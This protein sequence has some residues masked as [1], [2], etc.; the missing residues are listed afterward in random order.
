MRSLLEQ[1]VQLQPQRADAWLLLASELSAAGSCA[2]ALHAYER[3]LAC[4]PPADPAPPAVSNNMAVL[5]LRLGDA[6]AARDRAAAALAAHRRPPAAGAGLFRAKANRG[7]LC[8]WVPAGT[9]SAVSPSDAHAFSV[10]GDAAAAPRDGDAARAGAA[11]TFT[12]R[13]GA[14]GALSSSKALPGSLAGEALF[15]LRDAVG[16]GAEQANALFTFACAQE[17]LGEGAAAREVFEALLCGGDAAL[18]DA[19]A[20]RVALIDASAGRAAAALERLG[21]APAGGAGA[22]LGGAAPHLVRA[23]VA[24]SSGRVATAQ[25]HLEGALAAAPDDSYALTA[26]GNL[27]ASHLHL[28]DRF[29]KNAAYAQRFYRRALEADGANAFAAVGLCNAA[30]A[31]AGGAGAAAAEGV[32]L[33]CNAAAGAESDA[34]SALG[35]VLLLVGRDGGGA[36]Y[37][38]RAEGALSEAL[39][40]QACA[41]GLRERLEDRALCAAAALLRG[42]GGLRRAAAHCAHALHLCP[43]RLRQWYNASWALARAIEPDIKDAAA[44]SIPRLARAAEALGACARLDAWV[45]ERGAAEGTGDFAPRRVAARVEKLRAAAASARSHLAFQRAEAEERARGRRERLRKEEA[46]LEEVRRREEERRRGD[47][48][49]AQRARAE[50]RRVARERAELMREKRAEW[51]MEEKAARGRAEAAKA[52]KEAKERAKHGAVGEV[53]AAPPPEE[54][55]K[56]MADAEALDWGSDG[57]EGEGGKEGEEEEE[58]AQGKGE[59]PKEPEEPEEREEPEKEAGD[60]LEEEDADENEEDVAIEVRG[61]KRRRVLDVDD[62]DGEAPQKKVREEGEE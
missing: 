59:E 57:D 62:E 45:A 15:V 49:A 13:E 1:A 54:R 40:S 35:V 28:R 26:M 32:L 39:R 34:K 55:E 4:R 61:T 21:A 6:A 51:E 33:R 52:A 17:A 12:V 14:G 60:A 36:P 11:W 29:E 7:A 53:A 46:A 19:C 3:H 48:E 18:G 50:A 27:F 24:A 10:A 23:E 22:L 25:R 2:K 44:Y 42:G 20:S 5:H 43:Q 8:A 56:R 31:A 16:A 9:V 30:A 41:K 58:E 38:E 37:L 47:E